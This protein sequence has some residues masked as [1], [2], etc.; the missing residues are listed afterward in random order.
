VDERIELARRHIALLREIVKRHAGVAPE[1][2]ALRRFVAM[3]QAL[4]EVLDDDY[5][6]A[7]LRTACELGTELLGS[8]E[9]GRWRRDSTSGTVF[10]A[11]QVL[12]ALELCSSRLC[13]M[14]A[15]HG[16]PRPAPA[17]LAAHL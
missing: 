2:Q 4:G 12:N 13:N 7:K 17:E 9:H 6:R 8:G 11:L 3:C 16:A 10:L 15:L 1:R 5:C 14:E